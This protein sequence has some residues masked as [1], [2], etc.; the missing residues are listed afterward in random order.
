MHR[1]GARLAIGA[2]F[3]VCAVPAFAQCQYDAVVL[4]VVPAQ[5]PCS[6]SHTTWA[7]VNESGLVLGEYSL[8]TNDDQ[9]RP[10]LWSEPEGLQY[11]TLPPGIASFRPVDI[12][13][14][15]E[16]CGIARVQGDQSFQ[17]SV[18]YVSGTWTLLEIPPG[19]T[20][21]EAKAI[22]DHGE[23]TGHWGENVTGL[24]SGFVWKDGVFTDLGPVFRQPFLRIHDMNEFGQVTGRIRAEGSP[25]HTFRANVDG[26]EFIDLGVIPGGT[27]S[28]GDFINNRGHI[29]GVGKIQ[30]PDLPSAYNHVWIYTGRGLAQVDADTGWYQSGASNINRF[31][32]IVGVGYPKPTEPIVF[33]YQQ[34]ELTFVNDLLTPEAIELVG[35]VTSTRDLRDN[36]VILASHPWCLLVPRRIPGDVTADC[37]VNARDLAEVLADWGLS[38]SPADL[39]RD[40]IVDSNDL[41]LVLE[42]W[43]R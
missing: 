19:G 27:T 7:A 24:S 12:N 21:I 17:H 5:Q 13:G 23:V 29:V 2:V 10:V 31:D 22:T 11:P 3:I 43:S 32:M 4:G 39:N 37:R 1:H 14:A 35:D 36:G 8:C 25:P 18:V 16:F 41:T 42:A 28:E 6:S 34:G 38:D 15:G 20:Y 40:G 9:R 33:L 26:S 30:D